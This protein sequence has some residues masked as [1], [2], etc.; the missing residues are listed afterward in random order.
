MTGEPVQI[1]LEELPEPVAAE[2]LQGMD[3]AGL[4]AL[5]EEL[6][7]HELRVRALMAPFDQRIRELR[8]RAAEVATERRRRERQD[9]IA[10]RAEVR[11]G[12]A[13]GE[14][15]KFEDVLAAGPPPDNAAPF[16]EATVFLATGG[17]VGLGFATKPG[18]VAFTNGREQ[19]SV[20]TWGEARELYAGGWEPGTT[21]LPGIRVHLVGTRVEKVVHAS[22]LAVQLHGT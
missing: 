6:S 21:A 16:K 14:M 11:R 3:D 4:E 10:R 19:R 17:E 1:P 5:L 8:A 7:A 20:S 2:A 12:L 9:R 18:F 15:P 22:E 13:A